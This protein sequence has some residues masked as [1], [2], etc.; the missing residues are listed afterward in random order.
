MTVLQTVLTAVEFVVEL[1]KEYLIPLLQGDDTVLSKAPSEIMSAP[2]KLK[3]THLAA[4]AKAQA[5]FGP[6]G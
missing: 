6:R 4:E 2:L 5:K 1:A 3:A